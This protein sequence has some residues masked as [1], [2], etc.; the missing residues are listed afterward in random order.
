MI[1]D[2]FSLRRIAIAYLHQGQPELRRDDNLAFYDRVT[3]AGVDVPQFSQD[4]TSVKL[5]R[6]APGKQTNAFQ[7]EVGEHSGNFR[8]LV[9]EEWP[10]RPLDVIAQDSD[11]AWESFRETWPSKRLGRRPVLVELSIRTSL[12]VEGGDATAYLMDRCLRLS[13]VALGKLQ[14]PIHGLG[15]RLMIPVQLASGQIPIPNAG[16]DL[17]IETLLDDPSRL[18]VELV[19]KWPSGN[20]P[21]EIRDQV[22]EVPQTLDPETRK[23][24]FYF[25]EGNKFLEQN[26]AQF[27]QTAGK[28]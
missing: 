11:L 6:L 5:V 22:D 14:R 12:A 17:K 10:A 21:A 9:A 20:I 16:A 3:S 15:L 26:I 13:H 2:S 24:S 27:L 8:F 25:S 1:P 4:R 19:T 23:P 28:E 7:I 18:Y